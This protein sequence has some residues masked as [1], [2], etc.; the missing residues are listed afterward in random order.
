MFKHIS[1][2][3]LFLCLF[4]ASPSV[5]ASSFFDP[6]VNYAVGD[7]PK[8]II[9]AD[10]DGDGDMDVTTCNYESNNV[11]VLKNNGDGV[12][13]NAVNYNCGEASWG[14]SGGD[15]DGDN[16]FDLAVT[17]L[18]DNTIS[19]LLN[20]GSGIFAEP[21]SYAVD[22]APTSLV[23]AKL[24]EDNY[25]DLAVATGGANTISILLANGDGSFANAVIYPS[26]S[27]PWTIDAADID[28]DGDNDVVVA[29][30]DGPVKI[31]F[32][33][34]SGSLT[35]GQEFGDY[36]GGAFSIADIDRDND[37]DIVQGFHYVDGQGDIF[38]NY[39]NDGNGVISGGSFF[40]PYYFD[41][42]MFL[43]LYEHDCDGD[44]DVI[45]SCEGG[46]SVMENNGI[47]GFGTPVPYTAG[48]G[49]NAMCAADFNGDGITDVAV[50]N[51]DD[52]NVSILINQG[53][54]NTANC[55]DVNNSGE[56]NIFD[57]TYLITFLYLDGPAPVCW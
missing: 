48:A 29:G 3:V 25:W 42:N 12:F 31:Y 4:L 14:I 15:F 17:N 27:A 32:N 52:N 7:D 49:A 20:D 9:A 13:E 6:A 18:M 22:Y 45:I 56:I 53:G 40:E 19:I 5:V 1:A 36:H 44:N 47:G 55:G 38:Y 24:N 54:L 41:D 43:L 30:I 28:S 23:G 16:D 37:L 35:G 33:D 21:V 51:E 2:L 10:I 26:I 57:I 11:S 8:G 39:F 34:G 46:V 50:A